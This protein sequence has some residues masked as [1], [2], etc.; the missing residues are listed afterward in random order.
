MVQ[1]IMCIAMLTVPFFVYALTPD[2]TANQWRW[3]FVANAGLLFAATV[4]FSILGSGMPADFVG[5]PAVIDEPY[6]DQ[7][8]KDMPLIAKERGKVLK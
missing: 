1:V 8:E 4:V 2:N 6:S 5:K 7:P 3:V